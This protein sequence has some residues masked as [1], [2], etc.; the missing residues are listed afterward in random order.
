MLRQEL[1]DQARAS[2]VLNDAPQAEAGQEAWRIWAGSA[3]RHA[4]SILAQSGVGYSGDGHFTDMTEGPEA[5][6]GSL[7]LSIDDITTAVSG[8]GSGGTIDALLIEFD[9]ETGESMPCF[10]HDG[11]SRF[12]KG[13]VTAWGADKAYGSD[14]YAY[15][16]AMSDVLFDLQ[17]DQRGL[18]R[19]TVRSAAATAKR[20]REHIKRLKQ[21][22]RRCRSQCAEKRD[23]NAVFQAASTAQH[24]A[25]ESQRAEV[26]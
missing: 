9:D 16:S 7:Q 8:E 13:A 4:L 25:N 10:T 26:T 2:M 3:M 14:S 22:A 19:A 12:I 15:T 17:R 11:L 18:R 6:K 23:L 21:L 1:S 20:V 24:F 5:G